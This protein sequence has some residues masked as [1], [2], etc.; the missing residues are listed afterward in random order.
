MFYVHAFVQPSFH[1]SPMYTWYRCLQEPLCRFF[2]FFFLLNLV[3]VK[4]EQG[5]QIIWK[6]VRSERGPSPRPSACKSRSLTTRP[7]S[8][9]TLCI[10]FKMN[11]YISP[12]AVYTFV[13]GQGAWANNA[14]PDQKMA[15]DQS[16][17]CL[18]LIQ[19]FLDT[20]S[21]VEPR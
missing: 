2:F 1:E 5:V 3:H 9:L 6:L 11:S 8:P 4:Y 20:S 12:L 16:L 15:F 18:Q 7:S 17:N 21:T 13:F 19:H 14:D 10:Q